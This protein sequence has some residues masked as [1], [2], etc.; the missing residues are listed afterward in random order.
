MVIKKV[1]V[2]AILNFLGKDVL[3][4]KGNI[5]NR[6]I[7]NIT[8]V[9]RVN[10]N[11]LD[12]I[13]PSNPNKQV[14]AE[15]SLSKVLIVDYDIE[16]SSKLQ[17]LDKL[18]IIVSNPKLVLMRILREFFIEKPNHFIDSSGSQTTIISCFSN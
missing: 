8:N 5:G 3:D 14:A 17:E 12:W 4:V 15:N 10:A 18:L 13:N 11:S 1:A 9:E 2:N 16:Y 6:Y 7:D